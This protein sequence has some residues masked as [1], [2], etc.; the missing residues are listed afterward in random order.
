MR[1]AF[2]LSA[3]ILVL[4]FSAVAGAQPLNLVSANPSPYPYGGEVPP[5]ANTKPPTITI[6]STIIN[7]NNFSMSFKASVGESANTYYTYIS[8][9]YYKSDWNQNTT[10]VYQYYNPDEHV[11]DTQHRPEISYKM[12]V[13]SLPEGNHTVTVY[14]LEYGVYLRGG[15]AYDFY[16]T[17]FFSVD[18]TID[19]VPPSV[20]V[21]SLENTTYATSDMPLNFTVSEPTSKFVYVLDG[22][23]NVT[24]NGNTTL[25]GLAAG[26]HNVTVYA[27]DEAGN[28]G[29]SET[30]RF[31]VA[32][33]ESA[34]FPAVPV[35]AASVTVVASISAGILVYFKK[36][37]H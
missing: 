15:Y 25:T 3:F 17:G 26:V 18:F 32:G 20:S 5:D 27:W 37:K 6:L 8:K 11:W 10:F 29:A 2:P 14:A 35:A 28:M 9:V 30:I 12:N 4:L 33:P 13:T 19:T 36:R 31:T 24:V 22:Q 7:E 21:L 1:K 16:I 34:S 23:D